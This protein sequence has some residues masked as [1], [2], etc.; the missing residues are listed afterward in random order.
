VSVPLNRR[1]AQAVRRGTL[2][3]RATIRAH[4]GGGLTR[5]TTAWL[6]LSGVR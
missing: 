1:A 3:L 5:V 2:R 4:D 6:A